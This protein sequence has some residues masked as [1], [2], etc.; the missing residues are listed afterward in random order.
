M[1]VCLT[2]AA[3]LKAKPYLNLGPRTHHKNVEAVATKIGPMVSVVRR[4]YRRSFA[5]SLSGVS[6]KR[7]GERR[8]QCG[9]HYVILPFSGAP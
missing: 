4:P 6:K 7:A 2:R 3:S 1:S 5:P 9:G 8:V